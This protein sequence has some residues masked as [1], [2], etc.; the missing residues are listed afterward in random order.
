MEFSLDHAYVQMADGRLLHQK[1]GIP[2]GDA[3]SPGMT[4]G[5]CAWMEGEW[6]N[7]MNEQDKQQFEAA[8]FM[9]DILL[10]YAENEKWDAKEFLQ[11]FGKSECYWP[12]LSLE[13]AHDNVFLETRFEL[14][15]HG[16]EYRLKNANEGMESPAVWRY[17]H[18]SSYGAY[19]QRRSTML[20]TLRKVDKMA[21]SGRQLLIS[22][23]AKL[24]EFERL[25]YPVGVRRFMCA[26]LA[27]D[28]GKI[29]WW[30]LRKQQR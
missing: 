10:V 26:V 15:E 17:Q 8:R 29:E 1:E 28:T 5:T 3:I 9:D 4:I 14:Q 6:L 20:A 13:P 7:G 30:A 12:P 22:G 21:S 19:Q 27:R 18:W 2:M 24:K 23:D 25:G 11:D 16:F